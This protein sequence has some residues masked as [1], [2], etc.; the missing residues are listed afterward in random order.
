MNDF[1]FLVFFG[2]VYM[3]VDDI[4]VYCISDMVE[5]SIVKLNFVFCELNEWC[6]INRLIFYLGKSEVM[7]IFRSNFLVNIFLI[8]I[9]NFMIE[10]VLKL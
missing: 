1:L 6:F 7:L 4:M 9:G 10:W 5:K 3:F 8:F 2:F